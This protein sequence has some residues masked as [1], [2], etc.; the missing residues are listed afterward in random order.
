[1]FIE[2]ARQSFQ[3]HTPLSIHHPPLSSP[4]QPPRPGFE[5]PTSALIH[6]LS[7]SPLS[8]PP[9]PGAEPAIH[10]PNAQTSVERK[11]RDPEIAASLTANVF[12]SV[13][14]T[15]HHDPRRPYLPHSSPF[16]PPSILLFSSAKSAYTRAIS[17]SE[18]YEDM[19][20]GL[21]WRRARDTRTRARL[22]FWWML[23]SEVVDPENVPELVSE[24]RPKATKQ[25]FYCVRFFPNNDYAWLVEKDISRLKPHEIAAFLAEPK[26][27][28][29]DLLE[30]YKIAQDPA[31]WIEETDAKAK[32]AAEA[33]SRSGNAED[34]DEED[35]LAETGDEGLSTKSKKR[36]RQSDVGG[37]QGV[38]CE[39]GRCECEGGQEWEKSKATVESEDE[40]GP[41]ASGV[42][43]D[44]GPSAKR[45]AK[46]PPTKKA[47]RDQDADGDDEGLSSSSFTVLSSAGGSGRI[48]VD[49]TSILLLWSFALVHMG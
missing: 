27:K 40:H 45:E 6:P 48:V 47:K 2:N 11:T 3:I 21:G 20:L 13:T 43:E 18:K 42:D 39:E 15:T 7:P 24:E 5:P 28:K 35:Q 16:P 10:V 36:K 44:A 9:P 4:I 30:A 1:M 31:A 41:S 22:C 37:C 26:Q 29:A 14:T 33:K 49:A 23:F 25:T 46:E 8:P 12:Q 34:D 19:R 32:A 38:Y 17:S